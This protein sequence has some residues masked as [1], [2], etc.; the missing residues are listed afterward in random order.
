MEVEQNLQ[1]AA[2]GNVQEK[3]FEFIPSFIYLI[4]ITCTVKLF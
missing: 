1:A 4:M 3:A 2:E